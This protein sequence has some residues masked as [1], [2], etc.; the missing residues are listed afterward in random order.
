MKRIFIG[1]T[2][3][4]VAVVASLWVSASAS[5]QNEDK[6]GETF[7]NGRVLCR[8]CYLKNPKNGMGISGVAHEGVPEYDE[9]NPAECGFIC[10]K[11]GMPLA[12]LTSDGKLY[13]VTGAL[14][15][16]GD[17][18]PTETNRPMRKNEP[19]AGLV[20][21]IGHRLTVFGVVTEKNGE[22]QMNSTRRTWQMDTKDWRVGS[23]I[24]IKHKSEGSKVIEKPSK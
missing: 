20:T 10:S 22:L 8:T 2:A 23:E 6:Q 21:H 9:G 11:K 19:N 17:V 13:T 3:L 4:I 5:Q 7:I 1:L 24:E 18:M 12:I 16:P 14:A 15:E